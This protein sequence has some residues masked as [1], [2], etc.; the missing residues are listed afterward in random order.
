MHYKTH[1]L[2]PLFV[3][4]IKLRKDSPLVHTFPSHEMEEPYRRSNTLI[5]RLPRGHRGVAIGWWRRTTRTEEQALL[6]ALQGRKMTDDEF[7][8]A[9]NDVLDL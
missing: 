6:E 1:D 2:G 4:G 7:S 5:L 3:H 9:L 8:A